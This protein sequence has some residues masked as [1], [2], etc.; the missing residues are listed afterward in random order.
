MTLSQ[1]LNP[2]KALIFRITHRDNLPWLLSNGLYSAS[3]PQQDP[4]FVPIG[5]GDLIAHRATRHIDIPPHGTLNDYVPF[6][7]TP[8]SPMMLNI[9][10]GRGVAKRDNEE[11]VILVSSLRKLQTAGIPFVY[12]DR[13]AYLEAA[14]FSSDLDMLATR[15]P[16][17]LLQNRD[18]KKDP[19]NPLKSE[20][21]QAEALVY[22]HL[23][24]SL[25]LG[26]ICH[27]ETVS[28]ST[29]DLVTARGLT[30]AVHTKPGWYF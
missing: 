1:K 24:A 28:E 30:I 4:G 21:Y 16:W 23:P 8:Y 19:D 10:T 26:I 12:S 29:T 11:I 2:G 17:S 7:F 18:F 5:K 22:Q 15:I 14:R 6:Y 3:A 25:L 27:N 13:H 9:H 20:S